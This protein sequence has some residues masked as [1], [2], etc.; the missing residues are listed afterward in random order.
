[1]ISE[2][3]W[4]AAKERGSEQWKK[5]RKFADGFDSTKLSGQTSEVIDGALSKIKNAVKKQEKP[6]PEKTPAP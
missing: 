1:M 3:L 2:V 4:S 5:I 6:E